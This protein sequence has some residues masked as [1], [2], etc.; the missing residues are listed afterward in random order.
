M[1]KTL[2]FKTREL[3]K[4][5][6]SALEV[7]FSLDEVKTTVWECELKNQSLLYVMND[8]N[9]SDLLLKGI[10]SSFITLIPKVT[11]STFIKHSYR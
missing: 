10:N 8:F 11:G 1:G 9:S 5:S 7:S 4:L 6:P 2:L 3:K